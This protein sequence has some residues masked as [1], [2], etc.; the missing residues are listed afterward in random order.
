MVI[1]RLT[2]SQAF[3]TLVC[4]LSGNEL[5]SGKRQHTILE[6]DPRRKK[7]LYRSVVK[8]ILR[9]ALKSSHFSQRGLQKPMACHIMQLYIYIYILKKKKKLLL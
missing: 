6:P 5:D 4:L 1:L 7:K 9:R 2:P 8:C 3:V